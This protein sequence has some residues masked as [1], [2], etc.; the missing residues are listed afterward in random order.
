MKQNKQGFKQKVFLKALEE[1]GNDKGIS[2]DAIV[3]IIQETFQITYSKKL[4]DEARIFKGKSS[5]KGLNKVKLSDA[6][7][8]CD[9]DFNKIIFNIIIIN[10]FKLTIYIDN[11]FL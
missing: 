9:I 1:M 3:Q 4:E 8:R 7:V 2:Q 5:N 11:T 10:N 6:L